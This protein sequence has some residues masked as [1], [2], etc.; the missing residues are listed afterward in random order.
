MKQDIVTPASSVH[1]K[2]LASLNIYGTIFAGYCLWQRISHTGQRTK[3]PHQ[4]KSSVLLCQPG[5]LA[6]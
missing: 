5:K 3:C 2:P 6:G 4:T 1:Q